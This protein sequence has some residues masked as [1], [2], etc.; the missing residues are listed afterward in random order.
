MREGH[1]LETYDEVYRQAP[2]YWGREPNDLCRK[3]LA[4]VDPDKRT[5]LR[6]IDLGCGEGRDLIYLAHHGL[7]VTGVDLSLPG[8]AKAKQWAEKERLSITTEQADLNEYRLEGAFDLVYSSGTLTF[9]RP[10]RRGEV[11]AHYKEATRAGGLHAFNVFVEKPYLPT[12]PDWGLDEHFFRSGELLGF[13]WDW[14]IL[15]FEE[16][17]FDCASG[18]I[19]HRH[20]MNVLVARKV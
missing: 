8:L 5:G 10:V 19:Q 17:T 6:A 9:V 7:K 4:F 16:I 12:P 11:F 2:F 18:G 3:A 14:E 1:R 13:Y 20:A 15:T